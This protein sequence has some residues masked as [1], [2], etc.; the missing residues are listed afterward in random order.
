MSSREFL[1]AEIQ[2]LESELAKVHTFQ[3]KAQ[4][5]IEAY[6]MLL[7]KLDEPCGSDLS[8]SSDAR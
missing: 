4:G 1:E 7:T 5:V 6:R 8:E 2:H 3:I